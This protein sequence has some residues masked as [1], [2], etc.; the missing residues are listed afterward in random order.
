ML[1][2]WKCFH[3]I[4]RNLGRLEATQAK[5]NYYI[6]TSF[7]EAHEHAQKKIHSFIGI[8]EE[9]EVKDTRIPF[10]QPIASRDQGQSMFSNQAAH[11]SLSEK[12]KKMLDGLDIDVDH[13]WIS[14]AI[15]SPQKVIAVNR[16]K[17]AIGKMMMNPVILMRE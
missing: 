12:G 6:L 2:N 1:P 10:R 16:M 8:E 15:F 13:L 11:K 9:E 3:F 4:A 17:G 5:R 14:G 7:I